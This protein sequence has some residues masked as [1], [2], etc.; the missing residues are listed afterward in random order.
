MRVGMAWTAHS[1]VFDRP[2]SGASKTDYGIRFS[3]IAINA[4]VF[5]GNTMCTSVQ[6]PQVQSPHRPS[7]PG[8]IQSLLQPI[9]RDD[10]DALSREAQWE[11][12]ASLRPQGLFSRY[13][14]VFQRLHL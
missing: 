10:I 1:L 4:S 8:Q 6:I 12:Y 14:R 3:F 9:D 5:W 7:C 13:Y 2:V 11:T